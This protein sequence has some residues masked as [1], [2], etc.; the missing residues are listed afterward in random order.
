MSI[1]TPLMENPATQRNQQTQE[2]QKGKYGKNLF[3]EVEW[4][5]YCV[6]ITWCHN[7]RRILSL[8]AHTICL[9]VCLFESKVWH[10]QGFV[11][12]V[13]YIHVVREKLSAS[14]VGECVENK[15]GMLRR[16]RPITLHTKSIHQHQF[17]PFLL[18][19]VANFKSS[20]F[21]SFFIYGIMDGNQSS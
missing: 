14:Q 19:E 12:C 2:L 16:I 13:L 4:A 3:D 18:V 20:E 8:I 17:S 7:S 10:V 5:C 9:I 6:V 15:Q 1:I 21:H 11:C